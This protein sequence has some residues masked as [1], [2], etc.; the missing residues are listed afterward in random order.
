[1][2]ALEASALMSP[3]LSNS[4]ITFLNNLV[5][6]NLKKNKSQLTTLPLHDVT[7]TYTQ[8]TPILQ[9]RTSTSLFLLFNYQNKFCDCSVFAPRT[10]PCSLLANRS[11][12]FHFCTQPSIA[13]PP[14][15]VRHSILAITPYL[16]IL[17][18][19]Y[20]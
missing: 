9:M 10:D 20:V 16:Y 15:R 3:A 14:Y 1:M 5:H 19:S 18:F 13:L 11:L 17:A 2:S 6:V 12:I 8:R 7:H 4:T